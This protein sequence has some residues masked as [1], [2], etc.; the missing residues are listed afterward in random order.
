[1]IIEACNNRS[2]QTEGRPFEIALTAGLHRHKAVV[3]EA[4]SGHRHA[5]SLS[6]RQS[7]P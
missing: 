1:M 6:L 3:D 7:E 5:G 4:C 2:Q